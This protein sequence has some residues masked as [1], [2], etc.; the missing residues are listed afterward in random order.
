[1][2][3]DSFVI[4]MMNDC[5]ALCFLLCHITHDVTYFAQDRIHGISNEL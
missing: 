1:M 2:W 3:F 5:S 4:F